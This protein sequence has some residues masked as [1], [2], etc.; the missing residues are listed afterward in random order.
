VNALLLEIAAPP[1]VAAPV[2]PGA[3]AAMV[4]FLV[5]AAMYMLGRV[6]ARA[7]LLRSAVRLVALLAVG[8]V[9]LAFAGGLFALVLL[10]ER[11]L[12]S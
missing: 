3:N 9:L 2:D 4:A 7:E 1:P 10:A 11:L 5:L 6:V 12:Q 8:A